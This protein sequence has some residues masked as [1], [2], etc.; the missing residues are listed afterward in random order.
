MSEFIQVLTADEA[1]PLADRRGGRAER[2]VDRCPGG[3]LEYRRVEERDEFLDIAWQ[4]VSQTRFLTEGETRT[5][6]AVARMILERYGSFSA[7]AD[8]EMLL[9]DQREWFRSCVEMEAEVDAKGF[10]R[11][12]WWEPWLVPATANDRGS[13]TTVW[14][15]AEGVH[16][17]I[18]LAVEVTRDPDLWRPLTVVICRERVT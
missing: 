11:F 1:A 15:V 3:S 4:E 13:L 17:A 5:L 16:S 7:L 10:A 18:V 9:P 12:E 8:D 2:I 14:Y 6:G